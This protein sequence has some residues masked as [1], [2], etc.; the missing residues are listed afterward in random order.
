MWKRYR[1]DGEEELL[2]LDTSEGARVLSPG[3]TFLASSHFDFAGR[4]FS[5]VGGV[6]AENN[7]PAKADP[8]DA[9]AVVQPETPAPA[10]QTSSEPP[11]PPAPTP[12]DS[13][14]PETASGAP[15][16]EEGK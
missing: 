8:R 3:D 4:P 14:V 10:P 2:V 5:A 16:Q 9:E 11:S 15:A 13:T 6:V 7:D 1:Y 12:V